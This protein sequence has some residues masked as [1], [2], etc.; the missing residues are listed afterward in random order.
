MK[1][2]VKGWCLSCCT[3]VHNG[4][5]LC[6]GIALAKMPVVKHNAHV[7]RPVVQKDSVIELGMYDEC[8]AQGNYI[9][10]G[11]D[12]EVLYSTFMKK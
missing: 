4:K 8:D 1:H 6:E 3:E 2:H 12:V 7:V 9:H 10:G 5:C 11:M